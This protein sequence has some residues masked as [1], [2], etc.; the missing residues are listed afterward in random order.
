MIVRAQQCEDL[1]DEES[2]K[3]MYYIVRGAIML[4]DAALLEAFLSE[5]NVMDTVG[6]CI[7]LHDLSF[8]L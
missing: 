3:H 8:I 2:L 7:I 4:N 1:E 6:P 5:E